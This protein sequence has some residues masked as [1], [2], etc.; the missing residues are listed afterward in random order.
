MKPQVFRTAVKYRLGVPVL[1][2]ETPCNLCKQI[3]DIYGDHATCC[4]K[5]GSLI[6]RHNS[7]RDLIC[8]FAADGLLNPQLEKKGLLGATSGR[9]P[10]DIVLPRWNEDGGLAIDVAVTSPLTK[11]SNRLVN[12][13]EEYAISQKH[14][15]YDKDF[16]TSSYIDLG[17][18]V[19]STWRKRLSSR[20]CA[21][22]HVN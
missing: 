4:T 16:L 11:S 19:P 22:Q 21:L 2:I 17:K 20:S 12:P 3:I 6:T 13:C 18:L 14:R 15:K 1:A 5:K 9:R 10:G 8:R 7:L